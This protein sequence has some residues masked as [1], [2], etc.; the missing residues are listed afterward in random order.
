MY[1][2]HSDKVLDLVKPNLTWVA[3]CVN[4]WVICENNDLNL[5]QSINK[6]Q[7]NF[8]EKRTINCHLKVPMKVFYDFLWDRYSFYYFLYHVL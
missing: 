6:S 2:K 4:G 5:S 8:K 1:D 3:E 7:T